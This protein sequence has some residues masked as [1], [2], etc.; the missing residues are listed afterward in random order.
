MVVAGTYEYPASLWLYGQGVLLIPN[1]VNSDW[2]Y[3]IGAKLLLSELL[4]DDLI[5]I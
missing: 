5:A 1:A 2:V 4:A 3:I